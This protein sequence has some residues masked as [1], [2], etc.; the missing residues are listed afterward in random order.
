MFIAFIG[1]PTSLFANGPV[2]VLASNARILFFLVSFFQ[3][4]SVRRR[5]KCGES[6][7]TTC[8]KSGADPHSGPL[9]ISRLSDLALP[10]FDSAPASGAHIALPCDMCFVLC[11]IRIM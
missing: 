4:P 8:C 1:E 11:S 9:R 3:R 5:E 6:K 7:A 2:L 10:D